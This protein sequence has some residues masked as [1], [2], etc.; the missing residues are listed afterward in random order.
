M[1]EKVNNFLLAGD[2]FMSEM[3]LRTQNLYTVLVDHLQKNERIQKFKET[4][5]SQYIYQN[6]PDNACFPHDMAFGVFKDLTRFN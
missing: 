6:E 4:G 2:N 3:H 1:N 5:D